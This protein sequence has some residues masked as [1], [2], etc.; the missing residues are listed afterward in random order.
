MSGFLG[1][2]GPRGPQ[3]PP[4]PEGPEGPQGR[5]GK[6]SQLFLSSLTEKN[7]SF[8]PLLLSIFHLN[9]IK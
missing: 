7:C 5:K 1:K 2:P 6:L 4:G 8:V 9:F 3:G